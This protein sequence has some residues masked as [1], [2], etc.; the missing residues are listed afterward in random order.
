MLLY[1]VIKY[2]NFGFI[3]KWPVVW[4]GVH[5]PPSVLCVKSDMVSVLSLCCVHWFH[6]DFIILVHLSCELQTTD[7]TTGCLKAYTTIWSQNFLTHCFSVK[8]RDSDK[9]LVLII[10]V[11]N[12]A[13]TEL[14]VFPERAW[15]RLNGREFVMTVNLVLFLYVYK[16]NVQLHVL[17]L[18]TPH[19]MWCVAVS[20]YVLPPT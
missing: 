16:K 20:C 18:C 13:E 19:P 1:C 5:P 9:M 2:F 7:Q 12:K 4:S 14:R 3:F 6:H 17:I 15:F 10:S 8:C 11:K